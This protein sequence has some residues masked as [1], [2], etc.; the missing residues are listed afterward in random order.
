MSQTIASVHL[1]EHCDHMPREIRAELVRLRQVK[2]AA[3]GGKKYWADAGKAMGLI[4]E[5]KRLFYSEI[6]D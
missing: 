1:L 4:E 5:D 2:S 6:N 3:L